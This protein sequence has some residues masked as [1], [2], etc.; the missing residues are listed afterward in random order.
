[1]SNYL[2]K[3]FRIISAALLLA[4][5]AWP[6]F[7]EDGRGAIGD[8]APAVPSCPTE[9]IWEARR[10][11][12]GR[13]ATLGQ[14]CGEGVCDEPLVRE[15]SSRNP[16]TVPVVV[17]VMRSI[18]GAPPD[19]VDQ[20]A[21]D[22]QMAEMNTDFAGFGVQFSYE[23]RYH[24]DADFYCIPPF[25]RYNTRWYD[26]IREMK[27]T[28]AESP[29]TAL[30]IFMSCQETG[31]DPL[32]GI[33]TFP[34]D[35]EALTEYGGLWMNSAFANSIYRIAS[36]ETGHCLGLWHTF[37]GVSESYC[38]DP[39]YEHPHPLDDPAA[40][41]VGDF[42]ADTPA[43]PV[44]SASTCAEVEGAWCND[45]PWTTFGPTDYSNIMAYTAC[46]EHFT[47][48]QQGRMHCWSRSTLT[49]WLGESSDCSVPPNPPYDLTATAVDFSRIH[50]DWSDISGNV[51]SYRI[52]RDSGAGF[53]EIGTANGSATSYVDSGLDCDADY[54]YRVL[55]SSCAGDSEYS[56]TA[57]VSTVCPPGTLMHVDDVNVTVQ[58]ANGHRVFGEGTVTIVDQFG[59]PVPG[60]LVYANWDGPILQKQA[61]TTDSSGVATFASDSVKTRSYCF[62]L[63]VTLVRL[64]GST[65]YPNANVETGDEAGNACGS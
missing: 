63:T 19:G 21:V 36:H 5:T 55:G 64:D 37:H 60:A 23:T 7:A 4:M 42:C 43:T 47:S 51:G 15:T 30:N 46:P 2:T 41:I 53:E 45:V 57:F 39:C 44:T 28:Y 10:L 65:Y 40:D 25:S 26:A 31:G 59:A 58:A 11:A 34:W 12:L 8:H 54:S 48:N 29:T 14:A 35:P 61:R 18:S 49:G 16:V 22:A 1:M 17:H 9:E 6:G 62:T 3:T 52:E 38:A 56:P 20:A 24:D 32:G 27:A 13:A 33:G 50:L